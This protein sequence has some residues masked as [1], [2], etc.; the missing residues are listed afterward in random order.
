M[1]EPRPSVTVRCVADRYHSPRERIIEFH[2]GA[3][4]GDGGGLISLRR[5]PS[6]HVFVDLYR[7][8]NVSV[9]LPG[10]PDWPHP[11]SFDQL[12][13]ALAVLYGDA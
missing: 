2:G 8:E 3:A 4:M 10:S 11:S 12:G 9:R 5:H 7:L 6:G 13:S 1:R